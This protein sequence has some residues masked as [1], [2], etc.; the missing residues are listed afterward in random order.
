MRRAGYDAAHVAEFG[1]ANAIDAAIWNEAIARSAV[2]V[3]KDRD[4]SLLR[5]AKRQGPIVLWVRVGN[6]DNRALIHQFLNAMPQI[7]EAVDRGEAVI[8][9]VG[10]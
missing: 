2:L 8:E 3:T 9:F 7:V 4:F 6:I 5:A 10:S 1:M